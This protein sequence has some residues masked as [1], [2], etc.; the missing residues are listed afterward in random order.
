MK[1]Y[2]IPFG[3]RSIVSIDKKIDMQIK[4]LSKVAVVEEVDVKICS[5]GI[6]RDAL[7][8][9]PFV[10]VPWNYQGAYEKIIDPDFIFMRRTGADRQLI[11][12]LKYIKT[13]YPRCKIIM[14]IATYPYLKESLQRIE[15]WM[16]LFKEL[17]NIGKLKKYI[18]RVVT[19]SD[20]VEIFSVPTIR[21]MNG[22]KVDLVEQICDE[23]RK[24]D[25]TIRLLAVAVLQKGHGYE[26][27]IK[28]L[29][30]YYRK[31]CNSDR[32]IEFHIVGDGERLPFL[33]KMV[34]RYGLEEK[35]FFYGRKTGI[36]LD[37]IYNNMDIAL[38]SFAT[39]RQ[40]IAKSSALKIREYLAK[41]LPIISGCREDVFDN[42]IDCPYYL[43]IPSEDALINME[44]VLTFYDQVYNCGVTRQAVHKEIRAIAKKKVDI[45]VTMQPI[46]DYIMKGN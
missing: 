35:I 36:E 37:R 22:I 4:E 15:G 42:M 31:N 16:F 40:G 23:K 7:S 45:S 21:T 27:C 38:G 33:K 8:V 14:E 39:Y 11:K 5:K 28:G 17:Y 46:I 29:A 1:S 41:G 30:E 6:V 9:L 18:D 43:Q 2:Y 25:N 3:G 10:D 24:N 44:T 32:R 19:Y 12:F 26:K 20:D 34:V 13:N